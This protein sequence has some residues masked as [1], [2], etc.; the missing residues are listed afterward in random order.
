M[1]K[2]PNF[3]NEINSNP[4]VAIDLRMKDGAVLRLN[5]PDVQQSRVMVALGRLAVALDVPLDFDLPNQDV[6]LAVARYNA[7]GSLILPPTSLPQ[8]L[9]PVSPDVS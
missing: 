5:M 7:D 8:S 1:A 6:T 9:R 4:V 3:P 2:I